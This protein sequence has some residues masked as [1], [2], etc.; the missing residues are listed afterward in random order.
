MSFFKRKRYWLGATFIA[1]LILTVGLLYSNTLTSAYAKYSMVV[2][3][4]GTID[5]DFSAVNPTMLPGSSWYKGATSKATITEI[6][7]VTELPTGTNFSEQWDAS[8]AQDG[9]ITAAI[10]GTKLYI[11]SNS[12][13]TILANA[14]S[15]LAFGAT[16][17]LYDKGDYWAEL[18]SIKN[19]GMLDTQNVL[20]MSSMFAYSAIE[21]LDLSGW[22]V[23]QVKYITSLFNGCSSLASV[24][25]N[26]WDTSAIQN[27]SFV[28]Y[29]CS[30]LK[31]VDLTNWRLENAETLEAL[32]YDCPNLTYVGDWSDW[33]VSSKM[34]NLRLL[35]YKCPQVTSIGD[36]SGWDVSSVTTFKSTFNGAAGL[37]SLNLKNWNPSSATNM[38]EM[39]RDCSSLTELDLSGWN[40]GNVQNMGYMF[41]NC[42][43]LV[44]LNLSDWNTKNVT[45]FYGF[46]SYCQELSMLDLGGWD[47]T[48]TPNANFFFYDCRKLKEISVG[49]NVTS[50]ILDVFPIQSTDNVPGCDGRWWSTTSNTGYAPKNIP[51]GMADTYTAIPNV[52]VMAPGNSWYKGATDKNTITTINFITEPLSGSY[53]ETWD[54][55]IGGGKAVSCGIS[56]T[57]LYISGNGEEI[58]GNQNMGYF[59]QG[60]SSLQVI[61]GINVLRTDGTTTLYCGFYDNQKLKEINGLED[62]NV[63]DVE[64]TKWLFQSCKAL[65]KVNLS[66]WDMSSVVDMSSMFNDC[67]SL[68]GLDVSE[69]NTSNAT[70]MSYTFGTC[71]NLKNLDVSNWDTSKVTDMKYMFVNCNSLESISGISN[72]DTHSVINTNSMFNGCTSLTELD[73][74]L[75]NMSQVTEPG[76]MFSGCTN[77]SVL[78][79]SG[80]DTKKFQSIGWMFANCSS[81][82]ELDLS[83]WDVSNVTYMGVAFYNLSSLEK[84]NLSGWN[85]SAATDTN[86]FLV[87]A[88]KVKEIT[89]GAGVT[90][91]IL[92]AFP[93]Q[94]SANIPGADGKWHTAE[95][96]EGYAPA[97]I[98]EGKADTYYAAQNLIVTSP[99]MASGTDWYKGT[100]DRATITEI[101]FTT[102]LPEGVTFSEQWDASAAQDGAVQAAVSGTKLFVSSNDAKNIVANENISKMFYN[103][104]NLTQI[105]GLA[106][107]DTS[108]V[109]N[110]SGVFQN[111]YSL[112]SAD[113]ENF[114]VSQVTDMSYM[115][116]QCKSI[117]VIDLSKWNTSSVENMDYMFQNCESLVELNLSGFNTEKLTTINGTF[118]NCISLT[119]SGL[120]I[121][122]FKTDSVMEMVQ[123]F[124]GCSSLGTVDLSEWNTFKVTNMFGMFSGCILLDNPNLTSFDT[125]NVDNMEQMFYG[126]RSMKTLDLSSFDIKDMSTVSDIV[127]LCESIT[128]ALAK[129]EKDA[130][131]LNMSTNKPTTFEFIATLEGDGGSG[132][133]P[134]EASIPIPDELTSSEKNAEETE[135]S[136]EN[137]LAESE[138]ETS[139]VEGSGTDLDQQPIKDNALTC[140]GKS[141]EAFSQN[142]NSEDD[143]NSSIEEKDVGQTVQ[144]GELA[145]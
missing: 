77:L 22:N 141:S 90:K 44:N 135:L 116:D 128:T 8:E 120:N 112:V 68:V 39:F 109:R 99:T 21:N 129:Y 55:S 65:E 56:G 127:A 36:L 28:F 72:W 138:P 54:G 27:A 142:D 47:T 14:D 98:P 26:N 121:S 1:L 43:K 140:E 66:T 32:F 122:G 80:W 18:R 136:D 13:E 45:N 37:T 20:N 130:Q 113:Y 103:F 119:E 5:V 100:T 63:G 62:W 125:S 137:T 53:T 110:M 144:L 34:T 33:G 133:P 71:K 2:P 75:W 35:F 29:K 79:I 123:T 139:T 10:S 145:A 126:C 38:E 85:T 96:P 48:N 106:M 25:M 78:K 107:L 11:S 16:K 88:G 19:I 7:F 118:S 57:T 94:S 84:L 6:E 117:K 70:D 12:A 115:F 23:S 73:L 89:V 52:P 93:V 59:M 143:N 46:L 111:C 41:W 87:G 108:G 83:G 30:S 105:N 58:W 124:S 61:N 51:E 31:S 86:W 131:F 81:M 132:K 101:E 95:N 69:W 17:D 67:E 102:N 50:V 97:D 9:S 91:N 76:S 4:E 60:F 74:N 3:V 104:G 42:N 15:Y 92:S 82:T 64:N 40:T 114:E 49:E 24:N 134:V